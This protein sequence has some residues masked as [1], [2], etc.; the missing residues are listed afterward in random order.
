MTLWHG[1]FSSEP[2]AELWEFTESLSFDKA[3][4]LDDIAGS[5]AHLAGLERA[6]MLEA[7]EAAALVAAL[8]QVEAELLGE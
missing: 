3:L 4:A 2:S 7:H 8:A 6:G 5:R 1:R